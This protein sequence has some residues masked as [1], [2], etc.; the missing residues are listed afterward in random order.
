MTLMALRESLRQ[1]LARYTMPKLPLPRIF[2]N[3]KS[4]SFGGSSG[5]YG[6]AL[7]DAT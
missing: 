5:D 7:S 3:L 4:V 2:K 6:A 1:F